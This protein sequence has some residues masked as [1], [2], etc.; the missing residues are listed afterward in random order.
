MRNLSDA[1]VEAKV[2]SAAPLPP[3]NDAGVADEVERLVAA[4]SDE[5]VRAGLS[6]KQVWWRRRPLLGAAAGVLLAACAVGV[7]A[8]AVDWIAHTGIFGGTGTEV[9]K[10]EWIGVDASDAPAA[11]RELFP[12]WMPLPKG[13]TREDAVR[14][15]NALYGR[16]VEA[17]QSQAPGHVLTQ[18][19]DIKR[20]FET[21]GR[22]SWYRVWVEA[23]GRKD[24]TSR[25]LATTRIEQATGWPATVSTDAGGVVDHLSAVADAAA[26]GESSA[27]KTAYGVDG[28]APFTGNIDR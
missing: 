27:V 3:T 18:A 9:D 23:D 22:C 12:T 17:A 1:Q 28:C 8:A 26:A 24:I 4:L 11:I 16:S 7:P 14:T 6:R 10:S 5:N 15:V 25:D 2:R 19:T 13:V 21:Y 20:M